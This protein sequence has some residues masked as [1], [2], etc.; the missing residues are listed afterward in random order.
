LNAF[1]ASAL[2]QKFRAYILADEKR[3]ID[4]M[5]YT[6]FTSLQLKDNMGEFSSLSLLRLRVRLSATSKS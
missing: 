4:V 6:I 3:T 1:F 5:T 2:L